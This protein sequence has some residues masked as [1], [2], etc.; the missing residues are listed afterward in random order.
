MIGG[1]SSREQVVLL[2][3]LGGNVEIPGLQKVGERMF[4]VVR[5]SR[6]SSGTSGSP[7]KSFRSSSADEAGVA[8]FGLISLMKMLPEIGSDF[9]MDSGKFSNESS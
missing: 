3:R 9:L 2:E 4:L 6:V 5:S 1:L 7:G 8:P